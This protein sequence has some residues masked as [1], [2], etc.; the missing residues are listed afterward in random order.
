MGRLARSSPPWFRSAETLLEQFKA[1]RLAS[2]ITGREA[3]LK[4]EG[5]AAREAFYKGEVQGAELLALASG[6][7]WIAGLAAYRLKRYPD[8]VSRLSPWC[9]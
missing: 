6:E 8:A 4:A 7:R 2:E 5:L 1:E 9:S 3:T